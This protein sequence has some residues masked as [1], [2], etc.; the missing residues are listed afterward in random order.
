MLQSKRILIYICR[1]QM[2]TVYGQVHIQR[3]KGIT[4]SKYMYNVDFEFAD[5]NNGSYESWN[6]VW[7][8]LIYKKKY[9]SD[10]KQWE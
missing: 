8:S 9:L 6:V 2:E 5:E 7:D 4:I 10:P 1:G 3:G